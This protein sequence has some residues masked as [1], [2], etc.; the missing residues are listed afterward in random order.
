MKD[1]DFSAIRELAGGKC[2]RTRFL[3]LF[4]VNLRNPQWQRFSTSRNAVSITI[5]Y[6]KSP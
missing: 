1:V 6:P 2:G 3:G 4:T 5:A